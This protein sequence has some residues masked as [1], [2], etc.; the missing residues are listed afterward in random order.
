[1]KKT[2]AAIDSVRLRLAAT[3]LS[4]G[5]PGR[6]DSLYSGKSELLSAIRMVVARKGAL[7]AR[8]PL[9]N[10][11]FIVMRHNEHEVPH[12]K[13]FARSLGVDALTLKML[14]PAALDPY[15][16]DAEA[17]KR[18]DF[19]PQDRRFWRF[20]GD[21]MHT[22]I[23]RMSNPCKHPWNHPSIH[24]NGAVCT[25][26]CDAQEKF[27]LGDLSVQNFREVWH[28]EPYCRLRRRFRQ[29]WNQLPRCGG[30]SYAYESGSCSHETIA[31]AVFFAK[32]KQVP[33]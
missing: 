16:P 21:S 32:S 28:G 26:T 8:K 5:R 30:C 15:A 24:W 13:E 10:F 2:V 11:R 9:V 3:A 23:C 12:L 14:N 29:D 6:F 7:G 31:E 25:C 19:L 4:P 22:R 20:R 17:E 18:D 33:A 27:P 1:L